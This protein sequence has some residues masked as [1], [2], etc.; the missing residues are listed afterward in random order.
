M[1]STMASVCL[2]YA[3][4]STFVRRVAVTTDGPYVGAEAESH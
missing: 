1:P 4:S 2:L 3:D